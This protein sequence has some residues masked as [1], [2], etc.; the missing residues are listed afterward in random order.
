MSDKNT[1]GL[2]DIAAIVAATIGLETKDAKKVVQATI[3]AIQQ[4]VAKGNK[5]QFR[6]FAKFELYLSKA[7][8]ARNPNTGDPVDVPETWKPKVTFGQGF[9]GLIQQKQTETKG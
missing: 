8:T 6:N 5:V 9:L 3:F 7:R 4:E 2:G 1:L